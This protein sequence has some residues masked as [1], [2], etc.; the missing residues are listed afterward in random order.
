MSM[1]RLGR[2]LF[3]VLVACAA[4][5]PAQQ[6]WKVHHVPGPDVDFTDLPQAVAAA[7]P[8][9][10]I[11]VY[12]YNG[13]TSHYFTAPFIDKPLRIVGFQV[14]FPAGSQGPSEASMRGLVVIANI[15]AGQ[16]VTLNGIGLVQQSSA[17][18]GVVGIDCAGDIVLEDLFMEGNRYNSF[19]LHFE[20]C[21]NVVIRGGDINLAG[22]AL[23]AV[24]SR[25]LLSPT[26]WR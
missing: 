3:L 11:W 7:A 25:L 18:A 24:D 5:L 20:R 8:G 12:W 22:R 14:G 6:V 4:V 2:W 16:C 10:E 19:G 21:Q 23:T 26:R 17:P 13:Q 1:V 9:D 15:P